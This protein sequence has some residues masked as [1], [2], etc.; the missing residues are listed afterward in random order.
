MKLSL[1]LLFPLWLFATSLPTLIENAKS[2]HLSLKAIEQKLSALENE[3][4]ASRNFANPELLLSVS[5]IQLKEITNRS[6][7]PMQYSAINLKQKIPYFGKRD[8]NSA[9]VNAK[10]EIMVYTLQEAKVKLV[11]AVKITAYTIWQVEEEMKI[12]DEYIKITNQTIDVNTAYSSSET[13]YNMGIMSAQLKLSQLKIKKNGLQSAREGLYKKISYLSSMN[14]DSIEMSMNISEPKTLR[15]YQDSTTQNKAYKIKEAQ[16][17]KANATLKVAELASFIDPSVQ[18]GYYRRESFEDYVSVGIG[19][20]LPIYGTETSKEEAS[21]K[22]L[23]AQKSETSDFEKLLSAQVEAAY[24]KLLYTYKEYAIINDDSLPQLKHMFALSSASIK[25]GSD[26]FVY[27]ELLQKK[28]ALE[29]QSIDA[30]ASY[31]K[32]LASLEALMGDLR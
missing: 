19:F 21:R 30:V 26:L 12:T 14:V 18:V 10:K 3:Y 13:K 17:K 23:L 24:A 2:A 16:T 1:L 5:D 28:L 6:L 27:I 11:E 9:K 8:A 32:T 29:E 15:H 25:N 20:S 7:E 22:L 31:Y 4:D